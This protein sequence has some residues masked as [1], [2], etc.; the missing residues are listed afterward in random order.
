MELEFGGQTRHRLEDNNLPMRHN[1]ELRKILELVEKDDHNLA[2]GENWDGLFRELTGRSR[3]DVL[4]R[5]A[6]TGDLKATLNAWR[7]A[8][9]VASKALWRELNKA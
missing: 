4:R 1:A 8:P 2:G 3:Y 9:D 5:A 6:G 7:S